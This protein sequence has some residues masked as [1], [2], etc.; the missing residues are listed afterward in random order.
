MRMLD[1]ILSLLLYFNCEHC[2]V[3]IL[4]VYIDDEIQFL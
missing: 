3:Q 2:A 4:L 1:V